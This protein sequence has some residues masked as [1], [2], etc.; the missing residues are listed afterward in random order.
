MDCQHQRGRHQL[1]RQLCPLLVA[2]AFGITV[3]GARLTLAKSPTCQGCH[4]EEPADAI[5]FLDGELWSVHVNPQTV[6]DSVHGAEVSCQDCHRDQKKH[7]HDPA[8]YLNA[9][10][11]RVAMSKTCNR[12]HYAHFTRLEES[13]HQKQLAKG[14]VDAPT[15]VDCHGAHDI[16]KPGSL[17]AGVSER[18]G[19]CHEDVV[20]KYAASV[21]GAA[22]AKGDSD[23]PVCTDCHGAHKIEDPEAQKFHAGSY[24]ICARCH[25]DAEKMKRHNLNPDVLSTFLDD[26]HGSSNRLYTEVGYVPE[27]P[28][29]T[30]GDCHG[31]H[32]IQ[33]F[34]HEG[35]A[36]DVRGR[37]SETCRKCH[38]DAPDDFADAWLAH[39]APSMSSSPLVWGLTW[40]YRILIP[41]ILLGLIMHILLHL[42]QVGTH[43]PKRKHT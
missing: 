33:P 38:A 4:A 22:L 25:A 9:R 27:A 15:C 40:T 28:V 14:D 6:L 20:K 1:G 31:V 12:C 41:T 5:R 2:C 42:W 16:Q 8:N 21:H 29:A 35:A 30:C 43:A 26:F 3:F 23:V 19:S 17:R 10:D 32:D 36:S 34:S 37:V 13:V 7:P 11:F 39:K 24:L 18:C